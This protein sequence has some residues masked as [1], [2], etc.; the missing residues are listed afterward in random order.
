MRILRK[1]RQP[2]V[3]YNRV[4]KKINLS[5]ACWSAFAKIQKRLR[6]TRATTSAEVATQTIRYI[7]DSNDWK[8]ES[9]AG[10]WPCRHRRHLGH[11]FKLRQGDKGD[12]DI[13]WKLFTAT[14]FSMTRARI[15]RTFTTRAFSAWRNGRRGKCIELF[16]I[17]RM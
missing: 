1:R 10:R 7:L 3:T 9:S 6:A 5:S 2:I 11:G 12:P 14:T 15:G 16:P 8:T 4:D 17:L 13:K